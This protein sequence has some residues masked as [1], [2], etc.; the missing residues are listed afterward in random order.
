MRYT[1]VTVMLI[2]VVLFV[3]GLLG[4][5]VGTEFVIVGRVKLS[6]PVDCQVQWLGDRFSSYYTL[7]D[8]TVAYDRD[9]F[10]EGQMYEVAFEG[11]EDIDMTICAVGDTT[12]AEVRGL[13]VK[14]IA[15]E[16]KVM[17]YILL[18]GVFATYEMGALAIFCISDK[19]TEEYELYK[20]Q[21]QLTQED[22]DSEYVFSVDYEKV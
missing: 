4:V 7:Y 13:A 14:E 10:Y 1:R 3:I 22:L 6:A 18:I 21:A 9:V 2:G 8:D 11:K 17:V 16:I 20:R 5:F 19:I 15:D 12:V